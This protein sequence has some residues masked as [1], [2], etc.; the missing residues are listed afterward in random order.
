MQYNYTAQDAADYVD[1][2]DPILQ[3]KLSDESMETLENQRVLTLNP[4]ENL[5]HFDN[6]YAFMYWFNRSKN[7]YSYDVYLT[8]DLQGSY[9]E[10]RD[11]LMQVQCWLAA[12]EVMARN[13]YIEPNVSEKMIAEIRAKCN[14]SDDLQKIKSAVESMLEALN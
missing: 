4:N 9:L 1:S 7:S 12:H 3:S 13:T 10:G 11:G 8:E 2:L 6:G 5:Y 14:N